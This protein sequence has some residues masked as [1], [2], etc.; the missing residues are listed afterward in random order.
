MF[1]TDFLDGV[2]AGRALV[3]PQL[4]NSEKRLEAARKLLPRALELLS[5]EELASLFGELPSDPLEKVKAVMRFTGLGIW[6]S[7]EVLDRVDPGWNPR[8]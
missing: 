6:D 7:K 4:E 8:G 5:D 1:N 2:E 3:E